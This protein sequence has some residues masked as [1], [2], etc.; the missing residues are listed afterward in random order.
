MVIYIIITSS[1][2]ILKY[3]VKMCKAQPSLFY[4]LPSF[5]NHCLVHIFRLFCLRN[6]LLEHHLRCY[7]Q[8]SFFKRNVLDLIYFQLRGLESTG[9][10]CR[11]TQQLTKLG[12]YVI[13]KK[14]R[15]QPFALRNFH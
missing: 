5:T 3:G 9:E 8:R 13:D 11:V 14:K 7:Q 1:K 6:F 12:Y 2:N 15:I 4:H 10:K